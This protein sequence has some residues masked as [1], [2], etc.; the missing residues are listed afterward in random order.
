[1]ILEQ[2]PERKER[3]RKLTCWESV[4]F[5]APRVHPARCIYA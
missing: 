2:I 1:M 3:S 4:R 5:P